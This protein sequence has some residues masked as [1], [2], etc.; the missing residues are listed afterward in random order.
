MKY[1]RTKDGRIAEIDT[2][3][4]LPDDKP[5]QGEGIG[6]YCG[7]P[8]VAQSDNLEDLCDEVI[9]R[10]K[11]NPDHWFVG[12]KEDISTHEDLNYMA[13]NW[14]YFL[15]NWTDKGLIY[16]AKWDGKEWELI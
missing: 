1:I 13:K 15:L 4:M 7:V 9:I 16:V 12:E 14:D 2:K 8:I 11:D 3:S 6:Q 5:Y 10:Q